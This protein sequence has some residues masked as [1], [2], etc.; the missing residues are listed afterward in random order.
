MKL[1]RLARASIVFVALAMVPIAATASSSP[2]WVPLK[3]PAPAWYTPE[4]HQQVLAAGD[5]GVPL[6]AGVDIPA[7]SLAFLGIRPGQFIIVGGGTLCSSN[8]VFR[9]GS[10][11]AIGTAGHCGRVGQQVTMLVLPRLLV[12]IGNITKSV[13]QGVGNDFA[14]ISIKPSLNNIVSPSMA[15][16]GGPTGPWTK[17]K[18]PTVVKHSGHGLVVGTGGTPRVGLGTVYKNLKEWRFIGA[19]VFGDSGSAANA[20]SGQAVGNITHISAYFGPGGVGTAAG[21]SIGRILQIAG[22][23]L[24][25]CPNIPWPLYGCP[26]NPLN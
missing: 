13:N 6:P 16:W 25:R 18:A 1:S 21:T 19:I 3:A 20:A 5:Q 2:Q 4:L 23:P 14:L 11:Y 8:F 7:S 12:D 17:A 9:N 15:H 10:G 24:A 26:N 22:L